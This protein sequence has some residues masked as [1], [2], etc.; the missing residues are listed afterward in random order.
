VTAAAE[1]WRAIPGH[2]G[3]AVSRAGFVVSRWRRHGARGGWELS[4]VPH[5]VLRPCRKN[6]VTLCVAGTRRRH[7]VRKLVALAFAQ[8]SESNPQPTAPAVAS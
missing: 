3:Y 1:V 5:R 6:A 4:D 2:D 7:S 8:L